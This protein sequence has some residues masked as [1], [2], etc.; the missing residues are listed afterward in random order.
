MSVAEKLTTE[1]SSFADRTKAFLYERLGGPFYVALVLSWLGQYWKVAL[2]FIDRDD[3]QRA[4]LEQAAKEWPQGFQWSDAWALLGGA[5]LIAVVGSV[6]NLLFTG[7]RAVPD[8]Y[9]RTIQ[10]WAR[11]Q[12]MLTK[13]QGEQLWQEVGRAN[14]ARLKAEAELRTLTL[15]LDE[16]RR[17]HDANSESE[18]EGVESESHPDGSDGKEIQVA[19]KQRALQDRRAAATLNEQ[20]V[21]ITTTAR[22]LA[23]TLRKV[24]EPKSGFTDYYE[25]LR[26]QV[27]GVL[28]AASRNPEL[29]KR[30]REV[31]DRELPT[32]GSEEVGRYCEWLLHELAEVRQLSEKWAL[33]VEQDTRHVGARR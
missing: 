23:A 8:I 1:V 16:E 30:L 15:K 13:E 3:P 11:G 33:N 21:N 6:L 5:V 24:G 14:Q 27:D 19:S 22:D 32:K 28:V 10:K 18:G 17:A 7:L 25:Q 26:G 20:L 9:T 4:V 31:R 12:E 2:A 29:E